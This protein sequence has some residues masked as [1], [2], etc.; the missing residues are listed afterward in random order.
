MKKVFESLKNADGKYDKELFE[1]LDKELSFGVN[2]ETYKKKKI[3]TSEKPMGITV[4]II[5]AKHKKYRVLERK[6]F[7]SLRIRDGGIKLALCN[8]E[9]Q[10]CIETSKG[11]KRVNRQDLDCE[12][13]HV[14][15][16]E[17]NDLEDEFKRRKEGM[18]EICNLFGLD[19]KLSCYAPTIACRNIAFDNL[20]YLRYC[21]H[22]SEE[23]AKYID[24]SCRGALQY[25]MK[26]KIVVDSY[27]YDINSMY[28]YLMS[29][30]T[31]RFPMNV[32]K[33]VPIN[34]KRKGSLE[35]KQLKIQG[36]HKYWVNTPDNY[37]NTYQ[38]SLL[39]YLKIPY[40]VVGETK[41]IYENCFRG[42]D[43]FDY[44]ND[45][46]AL[47]AKGNKYAK[48]VLNCTWGNLSKKKEH[49]VAIENI[50]EE[51]FD[52]IKQIDV[53]KGYAILVED[54][55][56][57]HVICFASVSL[58]KTCATTHPCIFT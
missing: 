19:A 7:G 57:K 36:T 27:D 1:K 43:V 46:F 9:D 50:N 15:E 39:D 47:K 21:Q 31:F 38:I 28:P 56:Y 16:Y 41:L 35:I 4:E 30:E 33:E 29:L 22:I 8:E 20:R 13:Y 5:S 10:C 23:E 58:R 25:A 52:K 11:F 42:V 34:E 3:Y 6:G 49:T 18:T 24:G 17:G 51:N 48:D 55:P 2:A 12:T 45:I 53:I 37:Y 14:L 44:L 54:R 26:G 32:G 40:E